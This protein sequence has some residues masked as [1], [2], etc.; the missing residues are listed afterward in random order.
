MRH[1]DALLSTSGETASG[2]LQPA[3]SERHAAGS[4]ARCS[5]LQRSSRSLLLS[6][7]H[8]LSYKGGFN[9]QFRCCQLECLHGQLFRVRRPFH[10]GLYP[11]ESRQ[12][13]TPRYLYLTHTHC[14]RVLS[15]IGLSGNTRSRSY[16]GRLTARVI[17][18]RCFDLTAV[19]RPHGPTATGRSCRS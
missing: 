2:H 14:Q 4:A 13:N 1:H 16:L 18:R 19:R 6:L 17:A 10:T 9:R 8:R 11:A 12:P 15:V 7:H 5:A 3:Y